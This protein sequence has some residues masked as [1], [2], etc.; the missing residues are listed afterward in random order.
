MR[1][2]RGRER[3]QFLRKFLLGGGELGVDVVN[4]VSFSL[5]FKTTTKKSRQLFLRKKVHHRRNTGYAI[6]TIN[7]LFVHRATVTIGKCSFASAGS[8]QWN[9][10]PRDINQG[11]HSSWKVMEFSKTIFQAWKVMENEA[12]AA[13][14]QEQ[15]MKLCWTDCFVTLTC[16]YVYIHLWFY[17]MTVV[18]TSNWKY[19]YSVQH[20]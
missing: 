4:L 14:S 15:L 16:K 7:H 12:E 9:S 11:D 1:A 3:S 2:S 8:K 5:C 20:S 10:L 6:T 18:T 17:L 13:G 19:F